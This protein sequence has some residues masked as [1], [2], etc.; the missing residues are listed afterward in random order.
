MLSAVFCAI[1]AELCVMCRCAGRLGRRPSSRDR[2]R[3][4]RRSHSRDR[5]RESLHRRRR[6]STQR[7]VPSRNR[8]RRRRSRDALR[9]SPSPIRSRLRST[10]RS[11]SRSKSRPQAKRRSGS[12]PRNDQ[13]PLLPLKL[14]SKSRSNSPAAPMLTSVVTSASPAHREL[15]MWSVVMCVLHWPL[16]AL[17]RGPDIKVLKRTTSGLDIFIP[18]ERS[19]RALQDGAIRFV[20]GHPFLS[21]KQRKKSLNVVW[22][23]AFTN[24][25]STVVLNQYELERLLRNS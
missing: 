20:I 10:W 2:D 15:G 23:V 5:S 21:K 11:R 25:A 18:L 17:S 4:H 16:E 8:E 7:Y 9:R 13:Q 14:R 1:F 6:P 3:V 22:S 24:C 19:R 12:P